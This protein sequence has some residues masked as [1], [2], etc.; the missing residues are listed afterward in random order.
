MSTLLNKLRVKGYAMR[1]R[2]RRLAED[3][4]EGVWRTVMGRKV[5]IRKG[6]SVND[7]LERGKDEDLVTVKKASPGSPGFKIPPRPGDILT[8]GMEPTAANV[9]RALLRL[10]RMAKDRGLP[11]P[12]LDI[13]K[14][15]PTAAFL[16]IERAGEKLIKQGYQRRKTD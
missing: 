14:K 6:E 7:A 9:G 8:K 15:E 11:I 1:S 3:E 4:S 12:E 5:F 16:A 10:E 2:L 13:E